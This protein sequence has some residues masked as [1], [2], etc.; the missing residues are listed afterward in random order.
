MLASAGTIPSG[1]AGE[2]L[3]EIVYENPD[4]HLLFS[5]A[6]HPY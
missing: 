4:V 5:D 2:L 1:R 6:R 3:S